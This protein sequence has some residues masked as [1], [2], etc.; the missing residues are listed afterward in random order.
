MSAEKSALY[1]NIME[2]FAAAKRQFRLH[3]RPDEVLAD[4]QWSGAPPRIEEIQLALTQLARA[5]AA[6][7][8]HGDFDWPGLHIGNHVLREHGASPWRFGA[9]DYEAALQTAPLPGRPL[10]ADAVEASWDNA[11]AAA[12]QTALRAIDEEMVAETLLQDLAPRSV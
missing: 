12:M 3:L 9:A 10:H 7:R 8:Y 6:L 4:G 5:G 11:L 2:S 1:R